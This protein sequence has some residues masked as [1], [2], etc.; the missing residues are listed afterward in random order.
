M[1]TTVGFLL[2]VGSSLMA[3]P[4]VAPQADPPVVA[5]GV[6]VL[7]AAGEPPLVLVFAR[8]DCPISNRYAPELRRL[9]ERFVP[10]GVRFVLVY[11]DPA[12]SAAE[13]E[14]HARAFGY[15]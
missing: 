2:I 5:P 10:Q 1:K 8:T 12:G 9:H 3:P 6:P 15:G 11:T 13:V 14:S 4:T 7:P